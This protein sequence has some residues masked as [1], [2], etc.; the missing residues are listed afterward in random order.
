MPNIDTYQN[1]VKA[2]TAD[3]AGAQ[4]FETEGRHVEAAYA[5]AGSA[6]GGGIATLGDE[7]DK[8]Q[9]IQETSAN[10]KAGA[11]AFA[12][13]SQSVN[14]TAQKASADPGNADKYWAA[15]QQETESTIGS[16]GTDNDTDAGRQNAETWQNTI[17]NE[18]TRQTIGARSAIEGQQIKTNMGQVANGLAQAVSNNP[19]LLP[20]AIKML[21][22]SMDD[23]LAAHG[24][25]LSP[26]QQASIHAEYTNPAIKNLGIAAFQ[27]MA[28]RNPDAAKAA[29]TSGT[30][31]GLFNG[32]E[33]GTLNRY[34]DAQSKAL[35][36]AGKA[37]QE[38][39]KQADHKDFEAKASQIVAS[40]IQPD[41]SMKIAPGAPQAVVALALHPGVEYG[42]VKS[43]GDMM[44]TI[45]K[46]QAKGTKIISDPQTY[47]SFGTKMVQG[48]LS[49]QE[50]YEART[51]GQL[52][53]KDT[54]YFIRGMDNLQRDPQK[55]AAE[56]QFN[57]WVTSQKPAFTTD[58]I[59][60]GKDP[61]GYQKFNQFQQ[62]AHEQF[63]QS[64]NSKGDWAGL[65][66]AKNPGYLGKLAPQFQHNVKGASLPPP[67]H[68]TSDADVSSF[69][70]KT[71][72][73][74][75]AFIGP[76]GK[77]YYTKGH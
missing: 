40:S 36:E 77:Q 3:S 46:D 16:I 56:T 37:Q 2:P 65:L 13:L 72:Q 9:S 32:D 14:D 47:Q 49:A 30:F 39:Q 6:I 44:Q 33:I 1:Q 76:D 31:A 27:T 22:G 59:F 17:R 25:N 73:A 23:Q 75:V 41:G 66:D 51:A 54:S 60:G 26:E 62:A 10:S 57:Q 50:V 48:N 67:Q 21:S 64:Y 74:G 28:Q 69:L 20:T 4:A 5:Q 61:V 42:T 43:L 58:G 11:A 45:L 38:Q 35:T 34:A 24:A 7:Y 12:T 29:L 63:E 15:L 19:T 52:S 53:D 70:A 18:M 55:K 68:F 71:K 8:S